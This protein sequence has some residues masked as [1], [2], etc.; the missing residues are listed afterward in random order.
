MRRCSSL[1]FNTKL[2]QTDKHHVWDSDQDQTDKSLINKVHEGNRKGRGFSS[3]LTQTCIWNNVRW[4]W[5]E[6]FDDEI[7]FASHISSLLL[8]AHRFRLWFDIMPCLSGIREK[9]DG[10]VL[11]KDILKSLC[12]NQGDSFLTNWTIILCL[13][14][15]NQ[16]T[17]RWWVEFNLY[18]S[19]LFC[20]KKQNIQWHKIHTTV[21]VQNSLSTLIQ[22]WKLA[23]GQ[24]YKT[25]EL[26]I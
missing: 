13:S 5:I 17:A 7:S 24:T 6:R 21:Q 26:N 2:Q 22:V 4:I 15:R 16:R 11:V 10:L 19:F 12:N 18:D 25:G 23:F 20:K 14:H 1:S 8:S 9:P 3:L